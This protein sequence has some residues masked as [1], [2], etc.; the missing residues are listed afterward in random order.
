VDAAEVRTGAEAAMAAY[1]R[2]ESP[3]AI[4]VAPDGLIDPT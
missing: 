1:W 2:T 4:E 3:Q